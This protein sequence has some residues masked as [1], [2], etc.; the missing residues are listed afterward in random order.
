MRI[1][2]NTLDWIVLVTYFVATLGIG[3]V[4]YRRTRNTEGFTAGNRSL[5]GWV[6]GLS[7]PFNALLIP[8]I[9]TLIILVLGILVSRFLGSQPNS[10]SSHET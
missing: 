9:G 7:S 3:F 8:V 4:F 1:G 5:L 2:L 10:H 6:C